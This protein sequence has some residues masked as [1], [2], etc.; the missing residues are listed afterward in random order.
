MNA[1]IGQY[2]LTDVVSLLQTAVQVSSLGTRNMITRF[3][4][5]YGRYRHWFTRMTAMKRIASMT[6]ACVFTNTIK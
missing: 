3:Q 2:K 1:L 6:I 5:L 4:G